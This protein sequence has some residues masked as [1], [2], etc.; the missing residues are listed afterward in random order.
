MLELHLDLTILSV[1]L[2]VLDKYFYD[3]YFFF[4]GNSVVSGFNIII[5][6]ISGHPAYS[7]N[8]PLWII[9]NFQDLG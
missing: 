4:L 3:S 6:L 9:L 7:P 2:S 5:K 1:F 8:L